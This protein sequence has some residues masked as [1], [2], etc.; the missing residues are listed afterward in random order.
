MTKAKSCELVYR[1][2]RDGFSSEVFH[3]KCDDKPNLVQLLEMI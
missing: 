2:T 1:A 3:S